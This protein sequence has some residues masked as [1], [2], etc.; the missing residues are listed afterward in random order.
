[1]SLIHSLHNAS[2]V[3]IDG[4]PGQCVAGHVFSMP[5][6]DDYIQTQPIHAIWQDEGELYIEDKAGSTYQIADFEYDEDAQQV[7]S[8]RDEIIQG[9]LG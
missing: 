9:M 5:D 3:V 6:G 8:M 4:V 1:M 2:F 7:G